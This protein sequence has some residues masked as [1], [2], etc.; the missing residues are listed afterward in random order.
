MN[1]EPY[2]F[3]KSLKYMGEGML[4]IILVIGVIIGITMFLNFATKKR[5]KKDD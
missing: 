2:N 5:N 1:F 4:G 3:V